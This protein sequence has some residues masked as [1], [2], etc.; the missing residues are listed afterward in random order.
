MNTVQNIK[1]SSIDPDSTVNVRRQGIEGN[2]EKVKVSIQQHGYWPEMAIVVRPHPKSDSVYDY[3]HV[4]GQC[5]F[6]ACLTLGLEEIPAF[7]LDLNEED[8]IQRSWIEN[9]ARGDLSFSDRAYWVERIYKQYN[10]RGYTGDEALQKSAEYLSV[11]VQ[12]AMRYYALVVLPESLKKMVDLGTLASGDAVTI[13][14]NTYDGARHIQ[15]QQSM[16][17]RASW[18]L[19]LDRDDREFGRQAL[20][21]LKH[22]ASIATL[23]DYV[24]ER[25]TDARRTVEYTIPRELY[26]RLME[27][28]KSR[29]E[30][31]ESHIV[32]LMV[33]EAL[34]PSSRRSR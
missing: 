10:G 13:V 21:E 17:D 4:T 30:N 14:R 23:K 12:T 5:R 24:A 27:W 20:Q 33:S 7:V 25:A 8:A 18:L 16:I 3:E 1:L 15:S 2:V 28:G 9:E 34:N 29:G 6:K 26:N 11:T 31:N 19:E 22:G 32:G